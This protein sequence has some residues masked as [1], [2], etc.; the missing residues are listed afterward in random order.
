MRSE[1]LFAEDPSADYGRVQRASDSADVTIVSS[2]VGQSW[3]AVSGA[4]PKMFIDFIDHFRNNGRKLIVMAFGNPYLLQQIPAVPAY[5]VAWGGFPASQTAAA[6][7]FLGN[8][9]ITGK[10]P[11]SIPLGPGMAKISF[12]TGIVRHTLLR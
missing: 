5:V 10:L 11:I 7:A 12:G 6:R 1:L 3:D 2:Y 9:P 8:A 4:A